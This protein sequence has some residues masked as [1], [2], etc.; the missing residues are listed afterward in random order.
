MIQCYLTRGTTYR[1]QPPLAC[2]VWSLANERKAESAMSQEETVRS[3]LTSADVSQSPIRDRV[4]L[5]LHTTDVADEP[6]E[7]EQLMQVSGSL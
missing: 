2:A 3:I 5:V 7:R 4:G 6:R 1:V